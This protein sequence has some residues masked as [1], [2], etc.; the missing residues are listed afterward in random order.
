VAAKEFWGLVRQPQLLLLLLV[1]PVLIMV[2]FGL[3]L[4][5]QS[6]LQPRALVVVEP[7]SEGA[8]LFDRY[9]DE[10]TYRT[11]FVGTAD[12]LEEARERLSRGEV[13]AVITVPPDPSETVANGEQADLGV[14]YETSNPV[15]GLAVPDRSYALVQDLNQS[16]VQDVVT[17]N[18]EDVRAV[19][20]QVDELNSQLEQVS[21]AANT[22]ASEEARSTTADLDES[23][24]DLEETLE[25]LQETPGE[26]GEE[27]STTLE[28]VQE[29]REQLEEVREAQEEGAEEIKRQT[30]VS[31]LEQT[32][33]DLQDTLEEAP[34][35][36]PPSVLAT[37]FRLDLEN[38]ASP[39]GIV[40]FY[41]PGVL[42][43]LIQHIAVSLAS[44]SVIRERL[45]GTYE[46]FEVS[47]LGPGELLVGKFLTYFCVVLG[48]NLA[49]ASVLA[50]FLGIP[51]VGGV[52]LVAL[53]M[54]LVTVASLGIGFLVSALVK[55]QLQ[56]VQVSMLLL[57]GSVLFAGFLFPLSDMGQP[58]R[59]VSYLLP[60][61]YGIRS[62]QDIMIRGEDISYFDLAG[63]FIIAA[64]CL[65]LTRYLMGRKMT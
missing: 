28:Q 9:K 64:V 61:S 41:V 57:I 53:A 54:S 19:Q 50:V 52:P 30:G 38:L 49:V 60:A 4:D 32:L 46:F 26:T 31:E 34:T 20:E 2:V 11:S 14:L 5:V 47:P 62:L 21:F 16:I 59:G 65:V 6:I 18:I 35:D 1:G 3:S 23:L 12:D 13:D 8:E 58:A 56:A 36:A 39:P 27:A 48:A 33:G 10:F 24:A 44:L 25:T 40:G 29:T 63:L 45:S 15:F 43:L 55:S 51:F 22:L 7:G 17:R 37:P 42:A